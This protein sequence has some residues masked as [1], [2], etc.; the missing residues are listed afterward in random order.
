[1]TA[2]PF[3]ADGALSARQLARHA[4]EA[5]LEELELHPKPGLVSPVDSGAHHDMDHALLR[6]SALCLHDAF[7]DLAQLGASG[8]R[9]HSEL[10]P[11]GLRAERHMLQVTGG[12]NTHRGAIF[13]LGLLVAATATLQSQRRPPAELRSTL[14][15]R[16]G[17]AL[18]AH[19]LAGALEASHGG[20]VQRATGAGG[21]RVEAALGF[22]AIFELAL[23]LYTHLRFTGTDARSSG[24]QTLFVLMSSIVDTNTIHRGGSDGARHVRQSAQAFLDA[25]GI[26]NPDWERMA[27]EIHLDFVARNLSPGGAA[28]LLAGTMY[29]YR[30]VQPINAQPS[31]PALHR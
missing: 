12:I 29:V 10:I 20:A 2:E 22:P 30:V 16:W 28:D 21:A 13:A 31:Q 7:V 27:R 14:R 19:A 3:R 17:P 6:A 23:P 1:M 26:T 8:A 9:F 25:G 5:L 11:A 15:S 4:V 18:Q 24:V